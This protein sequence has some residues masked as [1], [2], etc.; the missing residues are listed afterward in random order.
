MTTPS[1]QPN[2]GAGASAQ[3]LKP[4][5]FIDQMAAE[6]AP[7]RALS[8][9]DGMLLVGVAALV[10]VL[11]VEL[12]KGLWGGA[13]DGGASTFFI[14][15]NGLFLLLGIA[16][17]AAVIGMASPRV[18]NRHEGP[19][20]AMAMAGIVPAAAIAAILGQGNSTG[21]LADPYGVTCMLSSLV[22]SLLTA[23][24]LVTWLKR[25]APVSVN[26]AGLYVGVAS[27][28]LGTVAYGLS[29][30]VDGVMHIGVWHAAPVAIAALVGRFALPGF[31]RW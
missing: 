25:G 13:F 6:L 2:D 5:A 15:A 21:V 4:N 31:L 17:A 16:A 28:A 30:P 11:A 8:M 19:R 20:W 10:T 3:G 14:V 18:G 26:T 9:R 12:V 27:G 22:A 7:V 29:C 1:T 23:T 24:A